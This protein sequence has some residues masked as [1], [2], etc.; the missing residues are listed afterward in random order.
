MENWV[1]GKQRAFLLVALVVAVLACA[2]AANYMESCDPLD[3]THHAV[4]SCPAGIIAV[5]LLMLGLVVLYMT[6]APAFG[7]HLLL[8]PMRIDRPPRPSLAF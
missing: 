8:V 3:G 4:T 2:I 7:L 1:M 5:P 6:P